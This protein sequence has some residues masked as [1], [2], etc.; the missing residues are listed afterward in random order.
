MSFQKDEHLK[1][2]V[3]EVKSASKRIGMWER[4][5]ERMQILSEIPPLD[6]FVF[7][8]EMCRTRWS[9]YVG[10]MQKGLIRG[11]KQWTPEEVNLFVILC[12][13]ICVVIGGLWSTL[14]C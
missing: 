9:H 2:A 8:G 11:G 13:A 7:K 5:A 1:T 4:I 6:G 3:E 14:F 10:P 12:I